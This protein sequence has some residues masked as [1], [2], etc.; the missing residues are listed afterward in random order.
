MHDPGTPGIKDHVR[1][2]PR[3]RRLS[4]LRVVLTLG[5]I[6]AAAPSARARS[7]TLDIQQ[8]APA[9]GGD[10]NF[11]QVMTAS[12]PDGIVPSAGLFFN[13]AHRPLSFSNSAT[14]E[15]IDLVGSQAQADVLASLSVT[16]FFQLGVGVP[17]T[18]NQTTDAGSGLTSLKAQTLGDLRLV[19]KIGLISRDRGP[20][21]ALAG[22]VTLPTGSPEDLQGNGALT[23]A[24][25]L[26]FDWR[27]SDR[28]QAGLNAGYRLKTPQTFLNLEVGDE[29][30]YGL[31]V[32][33]ALMPQRLALL[34]E[35]TGRLPAG[36]FSGPT[37]P[38]EL[39]IAARFSPA[40]GHAITLGGGPGL[41]NGYGTPV[42]RAY[43]GYTFTLIPSKTRDRDRDGVEDTLDR[44][45]KEPEDLDGFEDE[46]GCPDADNDRDGVAD[47]ADRCPRDAEDR[48]GFEDGD[49]CPDADNDRDGIEDTADRCPS[50]PESKNGVEDADGCPEPDTDGDGLVDPADR[51]PK[52]PEL[53]NGIEDED[54]CPEPDADADGII[55]AQDR[56]PK[57]P[58]T[59]NGF[60]DED[61]CPDKAPAAPADATADTDGDGLPDVSDRCPKKPET[62]NDFKDE[63]GCPEPDTDGDGIVDGLDRCP[64][65]PETMNGFKDED[66]CPDKAPAEPASAAAPAPEPAPE[67]AAAPSGE[68]AELKLLVFFDFGSFALTPRSIEVLEKTEAWLKAH[69][70]VRIRLQG[71]T[72]NVGDDTFNV[73]LSQKRAARVRQ[74]L[75]NHGI[76]PGR[77]ELRGF[78][79]RWPRASNDTDSGRAENR[80]VRLLPLTRTGK[81]IEKLSAE[82]EVPLPAFTPAQ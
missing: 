18:V 58:E 28:L 57:K 31:G 46:D 7:N 22:V 2:D 78:G 80:R 25:E 36:A 24:P 14:G 62:K 60:E 5:A 49:G 63:D 1:R 20:S 3:R 72:D 35:L 59:R 15:Q 33:Y 29:I 82:L 54:G 43:V 44:C 70:G 8:F 13:Y 61:G 50:D 6:A 39:G 68:T 79:E 45:P 23:A 66:G 76:V 67:P 42:F 41:S 65:K 64:K 81:I 71:F 12:I 74:H 38:L 56:C 9:P 4:A 51:C 17:F 52:E 10:A 16:R 40:A 55:D 75:V 26:L 73:V 32:K 21:L 30:V 69:P 11:T 27:F 53:K 19:A 37:S 48:D 77:I 34:A 47:A